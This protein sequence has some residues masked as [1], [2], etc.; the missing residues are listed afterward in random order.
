M[1]S[2][3]EIIV[4]L[5]EILK[6]SDLDT[7]TIDMLCQKLQ[8]EF[9]MDFSGRKSFIK[10]QVILFLESDEFWSSEDE[11]AKSEVTNGSDLNEKDENED[12]FGK[13]Y[14][15]VEFD[16]GVLFGKEVVVDEIF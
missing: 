1:G 8:E 15:F 7:T 13:S 6:C 11:D 10:D 12:S 3:W 4:R 16:D 2:D 5:G 9:G 14:N